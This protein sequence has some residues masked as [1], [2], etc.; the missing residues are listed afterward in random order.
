MRI[1]TCSQDVILSAAHC[2]GTPYSAIIGR[3]DL[4]DNDGEVIKARRE[5]PHPSYNPSRTD[6]DFMLVFLERPTTQDVDIVRVNSDPAK[7][8]VGETCTVMGWGDTDIR[9]DVS[10]LSDVLLEVDVDVITNKQCDASSGK[11]DGWAEDYNDQITQVR[12]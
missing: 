8:R 2:Q 5:L 7:P 9:G 3:H 11:I 10:D 4:R 12:P 6:N 1:L